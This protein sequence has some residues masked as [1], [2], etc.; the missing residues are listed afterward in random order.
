MIDILTALGFAA[1]LCTATS[2]IPQSLKMYHRKSSSDVSGAMLLQ[3]IAGNTL[4]LVYGYGI[5]AIPLLC[6]SAFALTV[7]IC[8]MTLFLR[9]KD[10]PKCLNTMNGDFN[11]R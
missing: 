10:R 2:G 9:Y 8:S 1:S 5:G 3:L 7:A 11:K 6:A 4:W